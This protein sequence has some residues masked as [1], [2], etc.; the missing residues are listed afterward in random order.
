MEQEYC[1]A[2]LTRYRS[3][4]Q[5]RLLTLRPDRILGY[6]HVTDAS[7]D[8]H[9]LQNVFVPISIVGGECF[10]QFFLMLA[11]MFCSISGF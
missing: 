11:F 4:L 3:A 5:V 6:A 7:A 2:Y 9:Y 1:L 10:H 8:S